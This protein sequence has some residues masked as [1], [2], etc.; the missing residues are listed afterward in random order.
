MGL[1]LSYNLDWSA[2]VH[3][4]CMRAN[5][6]LA[7]LRS[8]KML[9][10]Q[11]LDVLYKLQVRS[12]LDYS[13]PVFYNSLSAKQKLRLDKIQYTAAKIVSGALHL[14]SKERLYNELG[15]ETIPSRAEFLGLS[16]FHKVVKNET[17]PLI[18][19]CLPP[20]S[21]NHETLRSGGLMNFPYKGLQFANSFFPWFTKRYNLLS[22]ETRKLPL[23]DFKQSLSKTL[24]P[25]KFKHYSYGQKYPNLL[26]TRI[27]V[28]CS[29]LKAHS[30]TTGH[31][32]TTACSFCESKIENSLH[33]IIKCP[34]FTEQRRT[35]FDKMEQNF[36]PNFKKLTMK[37]Q[38]EILVYGY[39]PQ[40]PEMKRINGKILIY[41]Q[42]FI[43]KTNR[44]KQET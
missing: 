32:N 35:L 13:L 18:R 23:N 16:L 21:I 37:R 42:N 6:K 11:T 28:N 43:M 30:Y 34:H 22:V 19:E 24:K 1:Y 36:I 41:T 44:F 8:V 38:F 5:R 26:L 15:W 3:H 31:S 9:K 14:T 17:R 40:N 7:V 39:E 12:L 4:I 10:R 2:Q 25:T 29:Y 27:R 33:F 20:R